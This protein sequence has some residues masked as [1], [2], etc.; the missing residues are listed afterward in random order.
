MTKIKIQ[1]KKKAALRNTPSLRESTLE[2]L[3]ALAPITD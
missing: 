3:R 2:A 1:R